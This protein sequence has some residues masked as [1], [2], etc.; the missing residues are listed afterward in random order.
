MRWYKA[1]YL[2]LL[3]FGFEAVNL[4][5]T[6]I[7]GG[8]TRSRPC[9]RLCIIDT[10][11]MQKHT[12]AKKHTCSRLHRIVFSF[13]IQIQKAS[14]GKLS[15]VALWVLL[16]FGEANVLPRNFT[17]LLAIMFLGLIEKKICRLVHV[18]HFV[19]YGSPLTLTYKSSDF[20]SNNSSLRG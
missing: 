17:W 8:V 7:H 12:C 15:A 13:M 9:A 2:C 3:G 16:C 6:N 4:M 5:L 1:G 18:L 19:I 10:S 11:A 14:C 20:K